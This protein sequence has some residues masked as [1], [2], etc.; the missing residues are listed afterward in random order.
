MI[1][2]LLLDF[3]P[4]SAVSEEGSAVLTESFAYLLTNIESKRKERSEKHI[5]SKKYYDY[6][7]TARAVKTKQSVIHFAGVDIEVD[8]WETF[9]PEAFKDTISGKREYF[10][11]GTK[12]EPTSRQKYKISIT[13]KNSFEQNKALRYYVRCNCQDFKQVFSDTLIEKGYC[14][15]MEGFESVEETPSEEAKEAA[16][17]KIG[18]C[19]HIYAIMKQP[20]YSK[21][22]GNPSESGPLVSKTPISIPAPAI[23]PLVPPA[24][25]PTPTEQPSPE[26]TLPVESL[27]KQRAKEH[28]KKSL[29]QVITALNNAYGRGDRDL[30]IRYSGSKTQYKKYL[31]TVSLI[32]LDKSYLK[33]PTASYLGKINVISYSSQKLESKYKGTVKIP[34]MSYAGKSYGA[35]DLYSLFSPIELIDIVKE[36]KT[37]SE[38]PQTLQQQ[39][40]QSNIVI[41]EAIFED[42]TLEDN[43]FNFLI[44]DLIR[45][46]NDQ[47]RR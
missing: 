18:I 14:L 19:K 42:L 37:H 17:Q 41:T 31:F 32:A 8:E 10:P 16:N 9:R 40:S 44:E 29:E 47:H 46:Y 20:E 3:E 4:S 35:L 13:S 6:Y 15:P 1:K 7:V 27:L 30:Y 21:Y 36:L 43:K 2:Q 34:S 39:L 5:I 45:E 12:T 33:Y 22:L 28:I 23:Q 24:A 11:L 38:M 26:P 25:T